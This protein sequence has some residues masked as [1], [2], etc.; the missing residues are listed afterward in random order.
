MT[1]KQTEYNICVAIPAMDTCATGFAVCLGSLARPAGRFAIRSI[2]GSLIYDARNKLA[3]KAIKLDADYVMWFDSDMIFQSDTLVRLLKT[4]EEKDADIVSGLYF[5]R[6]A[7]FTPVVFDSFEVDD[8]GAKWTDYTGELSGVHE[9]GAVGFG[10]VLMKTDVLLDIFAKYGNPFSP[11]AGV[12]EDLSFCWRARELGYKVLLDADVKCG[13]V[14]HV[15]VTEDMY[16]A[17]SGG[18]IYESKS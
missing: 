12:G 15:T 3:A 14:G 2:C 8:A 9:V 5:R 11:L 10:C 4:L 1:P 6:A 16:K 17:L 7:P 18:K 13:H